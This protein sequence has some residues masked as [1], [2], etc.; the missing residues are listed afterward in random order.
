MSAA[1]RRA[2]IVPIDNGLRHSFISYRVAKTKDV[3]A[4]AL[5][6]GNSPQM[7][8][9]DYRDVK[10][11]EGKLVTPAVAAAWFKVLPAST[12]KHEQSASAS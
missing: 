8:F 10:T 2:G 11:R 5:E 1:V 3:D 7:I 12:P 6:A 4:V 9:A